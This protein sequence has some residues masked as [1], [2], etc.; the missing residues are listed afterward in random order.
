MPI[1]NLTSN[2]VCAVITLTTRFFSLG[3]SVD[4]LSYEVRKWFLSVIALQASLLFSNITA[5]NCICCLNNQVYWNVDKWFVK[6]S[7][8]Y[9][10]STLFLIQCLLCVNCYSPKKRRNKTVL[11]RLCAWAWCARSWWYHWYKEEGMVNNDKVVRN[12]ENIQTQGEVGDSS[13]VR[14]Y[15]HLKR[16]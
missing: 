16:R 9:C 1:W 10:C 2:I 15:C 7:T 14:S 13:P 12:D 4:F 5:I 11:G 8:W 3:K 6:W